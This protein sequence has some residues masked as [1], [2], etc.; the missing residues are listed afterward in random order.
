MNTLIYLN[1]DLIYR[2]QNE[3]IDTLNYHYILQRYKKGSQPARKFIS[4][5]KNQGLSKISSPKDV[6]GLK[7]IIK[8][9]YQSQS[10]LG[11]FAHREPVE[12]CDSWFT[13]DEEE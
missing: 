5:M 4:A 7:E 2:Y 6:V 3:R 8:L 11:S 12:I 9:E 1:Q 10:S 13:A